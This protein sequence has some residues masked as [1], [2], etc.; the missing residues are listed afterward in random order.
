MEKYFSRLPYK[1]KCYNVHSSY[2]YMLAQFL[3]LARTRLET[4]IP[5]LHFQNTGLF[6][7]DFYPKGLI[8]VKKPTL[9]V[10]C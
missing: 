5:I 10:E 8:I 1:T 6:Q 9:I 4:E 3:P 2:Y 7:N